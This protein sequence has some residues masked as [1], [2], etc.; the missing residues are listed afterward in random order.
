MTPSLSQPKHKLRVPRAK[1]GRVRLL[2][3]TRKG[4]FVVGSD[5]ERKEFEVVCTEGLGTIVHHVVADPRAPKKVLMTALD[6]EHGAHVRYSDDGGR[7][8]KVSR[9]SPAFGEAAKGLQQRRVHH[10]FWLSPG[11]PQE[12]DVWYAGTSPQ[13]LFRSRDA[14][15]T[16]RP[17]AGLNNHP[18]LDRWTGGYEDST[19]DGPT[20]HSIRVDPRDADHLYVALSAGGVLES[21]N[22]GRSWNPVN[23]GTVRSFEEREQQLEDVE[24]EFGQDPH[25]LVMAGTDPD[26]LWQQGRTGVYRMDR[27]DGHW[28]WV[29]SNLPKGIDDV[30]F[31]IL[32]HPRDPDAAWVF[33]LDGSRTWSRTAPKGQPGLY[34]TQDGGKKWVRQDR[35]LPRAHAY[36][37]VKRQALAHDA[38][39]PLGVYV[40]TS[41][42]EIWGSLNEGRSWRCLARHLPEIYSLEVA[43]VTS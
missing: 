30:G 43:G 24:Q 36:W 37:S 25:L 7:T 28:Q 3:G 22:A 13:G 40:G 31:A 33:P 41:Q 16:W 1:K 6:A 35:G 23:A 19:P 15:R 27:E 21:H 38:H 42:G 14:G 11:H 8:Y 32:S 5:A 26:R 18:L 34:R 2:V 9:K 17:V 12:A 29:G 10:I 39:D 4:A 20:L